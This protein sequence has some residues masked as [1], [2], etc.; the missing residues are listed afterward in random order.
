MGTTA[1]PNRLMPGPV[2][3]R[4]RQGVA[5]DQ[6]DVLDGVVLVDVQVAG[7]RDLHVESEWWANDVSRW[8]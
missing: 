6:C 4:R 2:T 3:Q 5:Q 7:R 8:S 1:S